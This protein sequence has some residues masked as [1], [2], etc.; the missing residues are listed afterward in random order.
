MKYRF[1]SA[2]HH[3]PWV[4]ESTDWHFFSAADG[5]LETGKNRPLRCQA[6]REIIIN[7]SVPISDAEVTLTFAKHHLRVASVVSHQTCRTLLSYGTSI[8]S[9]NIHQQWRQVALDSNINFVCTIF[10][11]YSHTYDKSPTSGK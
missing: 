3:Y 7:C 8:R 9:A 5:T 10:Q 2:E 6:V 11:G 4:S 1:K